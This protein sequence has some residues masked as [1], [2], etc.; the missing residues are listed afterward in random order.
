MLKTKL[1]TSFITKGFVE[2]LNLKF[3]P[4]AFYAI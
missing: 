1:M 4:Q 2:R 3:T